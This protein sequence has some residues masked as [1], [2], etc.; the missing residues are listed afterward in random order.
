MRVVGWWPVLAERSHGVHHGVHLSALAA[1]RLRPRR[2]RTPGCCCAG[3]GRGPHATR[4]QLAVATY[5]CGKG[6][7]IS[8]C[9]P[10]KMQLSRRVAAALH[11]TAGHAS[12]PSSPTFI[13][14]PSSRPMMT[15]APAG[16]APH[17]AHRALGPLPAVPRSRTTA[18]WAGSRR[19]QHI[20]QHVCIGAVA[21]ADTLWSVAWEKG[22]A[23]PRGGPACGPR[24]PSCGSCRPR[25]ASCIKAGCHWLLLTP[26]L[27]PRPRCTCTA[28]CRC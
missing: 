11:A 9:A 17:A 27:L 3:R 28:L 20:T 21:G 26:L 10:A 2:D 25:S 8:A 15:H 19:L 14:A 6:V 18:T 22:L 12:L 23:R 7:C 5:S 4:R 1:A 13:I 24:S 16:S